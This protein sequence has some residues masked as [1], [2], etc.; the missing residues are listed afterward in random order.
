MV[1]GMAIFT[2]VSDFVFELKLKTLSI[3]RDGLNS[4]FALITGGKM[5][6]DTCKTRLDDYWRLQLNCYMRRGHLSSPSR[7]D[8]MGKEKASQITLIG[9]KGN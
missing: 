6:T 2:F 8:A 1:T 3:Q 7:A 9:V 4:I 5:E